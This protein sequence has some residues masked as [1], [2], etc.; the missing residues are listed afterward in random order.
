MSQMK[1]ITRFINL[2]T[3]YD[4][5]RFYTGRNFGSTI[6]VILVMCI[7]PIALMVLL[8]HNTLLF[9]I[10]RLR[11]TTMETKVFGDDVSAFMQIYFGIK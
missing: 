5:W 9:L 4:Y 10:A 1:L 11:L 6:V 3:N 8:L 2:Q 7:I